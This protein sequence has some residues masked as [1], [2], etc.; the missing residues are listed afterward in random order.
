MTRSI[1]KCECIGIFNR[2]IILDALNSQNIGVQSQINILHKDEYTP[3]QK[4][5]RIHIDTLKQY[6]ESIKEVIKMVE[7]TPICE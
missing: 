5:V 3:K 2:S 7:D 1:G 4:I 6:R